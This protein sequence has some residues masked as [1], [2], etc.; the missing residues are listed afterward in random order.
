MA[1]PQQKIKTTCN[2]LDGYVQIW[3][4]KGAGRLP[5]K[6]IKDSI[7]LFFHEGKYLGKGRYKHVYYIKATKKEFVLKFLSARALS[8]EKYI[9]EKIMSFPKLRRTYAKPYWYTKYFFLQK[10]GRKKPTKIEV[11]KLKKL[12]ASYGYAD[13]RADNIRV[14]RG[15]P[16]VVD[17]S[18]SR[19]VRKRKKRV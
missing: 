6:Q 13:V 19:R 11:K 7:S 9:Q 4:R 8:K 5:R 10:Y 18:E 17:A 15:K 3:I 16:K 2:F 1:N 12:W 14:F